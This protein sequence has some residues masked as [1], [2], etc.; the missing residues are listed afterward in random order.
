MGSGS[1]EELNWMCQRETETKR[2]PKEHVAPPVV[3]EILENRMHK[4]FV[5]PTP[6]MF[7]S[8]QTRSKRFR[9]SERLSAK[10]MSV[11]S[12]P[13]EEVWLNERAHGLYSG[14]PKFH[15]WHLQL[16]KIR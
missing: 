11:M 3:T 14:S 8:M 9:A 2:M 4:Y 12:L 7:N 15:P 1:L 10:L 5:F 16:E 6:C 13:S